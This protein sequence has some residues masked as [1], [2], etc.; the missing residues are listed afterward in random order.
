MKKWIAY[1][2]ITAVATVSALAGSGWHRV[3]TFDAGGDAKE[4]AVNRAC[5]TVLIR[6][7]DGSVVIQTVVVREGDK[8]TP[9]SVGQ[10][11]DKGQQRE[12]AIGNN[13]LVTG[14]RISDE[15]RGRYDVF[16]K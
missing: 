4:S 16:V 15:G 13:P 10:R 5:S 12:I 14:L 8:K 9:H 11:L 6:V 7:T 2:L 1:S 3:G